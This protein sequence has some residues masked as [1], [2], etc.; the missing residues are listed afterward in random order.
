MARNP[1]DNMP[2]E[3]MRKEIFHALVD[4]QDQEMSVAQSRRWIAERYGVSEEQVR[5]IE[6]EGLDA[7]WPPL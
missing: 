6:T 2:P 4:A 1:V 3:A 5:Q 7:Q